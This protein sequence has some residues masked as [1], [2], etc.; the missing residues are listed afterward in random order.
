MIDRVIM[1][2][3][4]CIEDFEIRLTNDTGDSAKLHAKLIKNLEKKLDDLQKREEAQ[5][6][7]QTHPD[8]EQRMPLHIFKKLNEQLLK[9][10]EEINQALCKAHES[11][12]E[13]VNYEE[14]IVRFKDALSALRDPETDAQTKNTLLKRCIERIEYKRDKP[15]RM[16][17]DPGRSRRNP[18]FES[19]GG[20]WTNPPIEIDVKLKV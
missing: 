8:P 11:M 9:E 5:W 14:R 13:P 7:Q 17:R 3:E 2:L 1:V 19:S 4:Q 18:Q 12:P 16:K 6:N 10:R 15:E 20:R